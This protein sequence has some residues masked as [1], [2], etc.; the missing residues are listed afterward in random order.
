MWK[1]VLFSKSALLIYGV[2]I[3]IVLA[4]LLKTDQ[5][6]VSF[7]Q[8]DI[9]T[10]VS[11]P[12]SESPQ[13]QQVIVKLNRLYALVK[14]FTWFPLLQERLL[15]RVPEMQNAKV[16]INMMGGNYKATPGWMNDVKPTLVLENVRMAHLDRLEQF[17]SDGE[18][19]EAEMFEIAN[20]F[21]VPGLQALYNADVLFFP[22]DKRYLQLDN[23]IQVELLN[24]YGAKDLEGIPIEAKATVIN[25]D[26]YWMVFPGWQGQQ[27]VRYSVDVNQ[28]IKYY[29]LINYKFREVKDTDLLGRKELFDEYM[30]L[31]KDTLTYSK[32]K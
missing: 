27:D 26:G 5:R 28:M 25:V 17:L 24:K 6:Y 15:I 29:Y 10:Y 14:K 11:D 8:R 12:V 23:F 13:T 4:N 1:K 31:R 21:L 30:K 16:T 7:F 3:G 32:Y 2:V 20:V 19:T 18:L 9:P 22:G